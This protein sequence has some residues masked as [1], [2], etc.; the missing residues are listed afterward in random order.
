MA[1][2]D[3][4][5][6]QVRGIRRRSGEPWHTPDVVRHASTLCG[7]VGDEDGLD[8]SAAWQRIVRPYP[9]S[10]APQSAAGPRWW[11]SADS[12]VMVKDIN[13]AAVPVQPSTW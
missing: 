8:D 3:D 4:I 7:L 2:G 9:R 13:S 12:V 5:Q 1:W 10:C 6:R 11:W